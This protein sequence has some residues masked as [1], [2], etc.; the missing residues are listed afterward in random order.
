MT[1]DPCADLERLI[2]VNPFQVGRSNWLARLDAL[3]QVNDCIVAGLV[4]SS[5]GEDWSRFGR[6]VLALTRHPSKKGGD[7]LCEVLGR[8]ID[9]VNNEDIVD[10]LAEIRDPA[11]V[12]CLADVIWWLPDW[13][14][15]HQLAIK[16]VWALAAIASPEAVRTLNEAASSAPQ[17]VREAASRELK[18]LS[19]RE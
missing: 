10:A 11:S 18:A 9:E 1:D 6:Y 5:E 4:R 7:V 8:R 14:E 16:S 2:D 13:D 3:I 15:F 19:W 12:P 17:E